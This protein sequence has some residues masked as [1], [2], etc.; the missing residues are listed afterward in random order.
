MSL[1]NAF[2]KSVTFFQNILDKDTCDKQFCS[3]LHRV[4]YDFTNNII[5]S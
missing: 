1:S 3:Y 4:I 2:C 5:K